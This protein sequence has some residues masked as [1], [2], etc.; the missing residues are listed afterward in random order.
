MR[1]RLDKDEPLIVIPVSLTGKV[2]KYI[3]NMALDTGATFTMIPW[4][5]AERLGYDPK[6]SKDQV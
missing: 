6:R 3:V 1:V 2:A 4:D 5:V